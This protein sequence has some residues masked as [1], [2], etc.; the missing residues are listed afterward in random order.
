MDWRRV[1]TKLL[2]MMNISYADLVLIPEIFEGDGLT[3]SSENGNIT[4]I[5]RDIGP[6]LRSGSSGRDTGFL[7]NTK[8]TLWA[9]QLGGMNGS[10]GESVRFWGWKNWGTMGRDHRRR[11]RWMKRR[12]QRLGRCCEHH[13]HGFRLGAKLLNRNEH[14]PLSRCRW[15]SEGGE[16]EK[17]PLLGHKQGH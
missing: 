1:R 12:S 4:E 16:P 14:E 17:F 7:G 9:S 3:S 2:Y 6:I 15:D 5:L 10:S 8:R 11:H 13:H